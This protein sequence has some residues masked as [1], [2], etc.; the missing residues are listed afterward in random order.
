M[1]NRLSGELSGFSANLTRQIPLLTKACVPIV[2]F[3]GFST[4]GESSRVTERYSDWSDG[5][6]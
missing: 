6:E 3:V 2:W 4:G 1:N 5:L